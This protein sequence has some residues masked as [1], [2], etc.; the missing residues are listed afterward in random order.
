MSV[1]SSPVGDIAS[2]KGLA[3]NTSNLFRFLVLEMAARLQTNADW[4]VAV[5]ASET[6]GTFDPAITNFIGA[7]GLIQFIPS[8]AK[9]LGTSSAALRAMSAEE[10]LVYVEKYFRPFTGRLNSPEDCY[11]ATFMPIHTGKASSNVIAVAGEKVYDQNAG[12]DRDKDGIIT[13]FEVGSVVRSILAGA[14]SRPRIDV[15]A[16]SGGGGGLGFFGACVGLGGLYLL[17]KG[18]R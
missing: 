16:E 6:G 1:S 8:T 17:W 5:M 4:L 7:V 14:E 11:M 3:D 18:L 9:I 2:V 12:F 15:F 13:N 10:Q